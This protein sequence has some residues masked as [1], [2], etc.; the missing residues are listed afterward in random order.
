[1]NN[2]AYLIES[3]APLV[4]RSGK[5]FGSQASAQDTV[6][7]LPSSAAGLIRALSIEQGMGQYQQYAQKLADTEYQKLL[8]IPVQGPFLVR[9]DSEKPDAYTVLV[10]KPANALYFENRETK[11]T[12]LVRL[13]PQAF[14]QEQC[15]SDLPEG[16]LPV[17]MQQD[18]KGKPQSGVAYWS[19][20]HFLAWQQG[21]DLSFSEVEKAGLK[22]LPIDIRTHVALDDTSLAAEDGKLF[23]TAS[24][25]LAHSQKEKNGGWNNERYGFLLLSPQLLKKDM[26]TFGG[27]RRLSYFKPVALAADLQ[28]PQNLVEKINQAQGF[29][30]TLLTPSIFAN[31]YLPQWL[32]Q[33][34]LQ[35]VLPD[36]Q[37]KVQLKAVAIDRWF[38]VSGWD[39]V[40][41]KPKA[42]RKAV[43]AGSVYWFELCDGA[44]LSQELM[45]QLWAVSL[46]DHPQDQKDGFGMAI[47][48]PWTK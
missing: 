48:A 4:F 16:L 43:S 28:V 19:L 1:M 22:A 14:D 36:T 45:Q 8:S 41:W 2:N 24:F 38:A 29:S 25:D 6:F 39:S 37:V 46:A 33:K 42:T 15:G 30:L 23:Q 47:F 44:T 32:D 26:A 11:E 3:I 10:P 12:H 21:Q 35:G 13:S 27:E 40:V 7:P 34:T 18:I 17:Q 31:G 20:S 5:P 9:F